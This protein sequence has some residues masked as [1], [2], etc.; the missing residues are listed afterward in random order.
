MEDAPNRAAAVARSG[1]PRRYR[2][3][4]YGPPAVWG[5]RRVLWVWGG[6]RWDPLSGDAGCRAA[7]GRAAAA[8]RGGGRHRRRWWRRQAWQGTSLGPEEHSEAL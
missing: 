3:R 2:C 6:W 5:G 4:P 1:S 8:V 7:D